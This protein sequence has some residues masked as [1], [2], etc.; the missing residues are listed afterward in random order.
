MTDAPLRVTVVMTHPVQYFSPWFRW[1]TANVPEV[2][3]TVIYAA[4]PAPAQQGQAFGEAFEWDS[5]PLAGYDYQVC[6]DP[7]GL[8]FTDDTF[9]GV[10]AS[11]I[12]ARIA[13]TSPDIVL[14]AGWHSLF[15]L[16]ALL[17]CR[18]RGIPVVYR[19][20][21]NLSS[22]P[23]GW[24]RGLWLARTWCLLRLFRG[25]LSVGT[26][27]RAYLQHFGLASDR[28][29]WS[30]H[31]VDHDWFVERSAAARASGRRA[32]VRR[33]LGLDADAFVVLFVGRLVAVKRPLDAVR[34]VASLGGGAALVAAGNG[35]LLGAMQAEAERTGV[36]LVT[37]GFRNQTEIVDLY[38]AADVLVLPSTSETWGLVVNEALA[39]G[40]PCV[41]SAGVAA[42]DDVI[43]EGENGSVVPVGNPQAMGQALMR[44]REGL[45]R[46]TYGVEACQSVVRRAGF[47][48]ASA[49]LLA[50]GR[51]LSGAEPAG[52]DSLYRG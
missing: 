8:T 42:G 29:A 40:V 26:R 33:D 30:P 13:K 48:E 41:L 31:C 51:R 44:V 46:G 20:D 6:R 43:R 35:P 27:A 14:I 17:A 37:T 23:G 1:I 39:S 11:G 25:W 28:V 24:W 21:S 32:A 16:R 15:Q 38:V 4:V 52:P 9:W 19:G 18:W 10:D 45:T 3:L 22:V 12:G 50:L 36:R 49:G 2:A 47:R 34:A 7:E 5:Q